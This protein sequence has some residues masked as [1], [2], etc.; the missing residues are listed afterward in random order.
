M[1]E[2]R[3]TGNSKGRMLPASIRGLATNG[4]KTELGVTGVKLHKRDDPGKSRMALGDRLSTL[5]S[6]LDRA[7]VEKERR[8]VQPRCSCTKEI[9]KLGKDERLA[10]SCLL[11]SPPRPMLVADMVCGSGGWDW[12]CIKHVLPRELVEQIATVHPPRCD[13]GANKPIWRWGDKRQFTTRSAYEFLSDRAVTHGVGEWR[14]IWKILVPFA[15]ICWL[16]WKRRCC[17]VLASRE[18]YR[19]DILVCGDRMVEE[20]KHAFCSNQQVLRQPIVQSSWLAPPHGW[21][22]LNVDASVSSLDHKAGVGGV[23]RDELGHWIFGFS[24]FLGHCDSLVAELWAIHVGLLQAWDSDYTRVELESD[25]LEAVSIINSSSTALD[26]SALVT[27]IKDVI[28]RE[29]T[30][31]TQDV[32]RG[33]N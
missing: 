21:V 17:L 23:L 13:A 1:G 9:N 26:G 8:L 10:F 7:A 29:W 32:G 25:C 27:S 11:P 6:D 30:V 2:G 19:D 12:C 18:S 14:R 4:P 3:E 22:K 24:H 15:V 31:V 5:A 28:D 33:N 16:I 20:R